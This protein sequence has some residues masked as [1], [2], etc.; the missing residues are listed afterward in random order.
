MSDVLERQGL[1]EFVIKTGYVLDP[2]KTF[3]CPWE[4][5]GVQVFE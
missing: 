1:L 5:S 3:C 2:W 4:F